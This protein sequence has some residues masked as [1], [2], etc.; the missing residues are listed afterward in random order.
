VCR[1]WQNPLRCPELGRGKWKIKSRYFHPGCET[2]AKEWILVR[3]DEQLKIKVFVSNQGIKGAKHRLLTIAASTAL[4]VIPFELMPKPRALGH[5]HAFHH[6]IEKW[7][8]YNVCFLVDGSNASID[9]LPVTS[10]L[11]AQAEQSVVEKLSDHLP[12]IKKVT[13]TKGINIKVNQEAV[14]R[15]FPDKKY[16]KK[17]LILEPFFS[18]DFLQ[19]MEEKPLAL[20]FKCISKSPGKTHICLVLVNKQNLLCSTQTWESATVTHEAAREYEI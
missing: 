4:P 3:G 16:E 15:V 20:K 5:L 7:I 12:V 2:A 9:L 8:F 13:P 14:I 18:T 1:D 19:L 17:F 11:Q 6:R 10:W